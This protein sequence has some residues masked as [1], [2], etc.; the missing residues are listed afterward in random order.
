MPNSMWSSKNLFMT[1]LVKRGPSSYHYYLSTGI[2]VLSFHISRHI[3]PHQVAERTT[4]VPRRRFPY[5]ALMTGE[6]ADARF[7]LGDV[8][9]IINLTRGEHGLPANDTDTG[10]TRTPV[11]GK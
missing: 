3:Y 1:Q 10:S 4:L 11:S 6:M 9:H 8:Q 7:V 5:P 2:T